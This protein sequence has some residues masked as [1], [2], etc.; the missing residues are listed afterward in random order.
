M[1]RLERLRTSDGR[2]R[3]FVL[4]DSVLQWIPAFAG[5]T[6]K[7]TGMTGGAQGWEF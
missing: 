4:V 6:T 3:F 1:E 2:G 5:M 7:G